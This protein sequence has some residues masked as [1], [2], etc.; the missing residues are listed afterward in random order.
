MYFIHHM[1]YV[2]LVALVFESDVWL[3]YFSYTYKY[4]AAFVRRHL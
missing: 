2:V 3:R 4:L 1:H